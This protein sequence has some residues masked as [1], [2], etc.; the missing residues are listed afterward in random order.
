MSPVD[1]PWRE[2]LRIVIRTGFFFLLLLAV[3]VLWR[4]STSF[5][6]EGF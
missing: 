6:Y 4:G 2:V 5:L 3:L 1:S